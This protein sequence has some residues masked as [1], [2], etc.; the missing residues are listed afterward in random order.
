MSYK[1]ARSAH[2]RV[3]KVISLISLLVFVGIAPLSSVQAGVLSDFFA[4]LKK[5][6]ERSE[7]TST[8]NLQTIELPKPAMN[9]DPSAGRGGGDITIVDGSALMPEEGPAGTI[10]DIEK[11]K[12][13]TIS[14]YMVRPGDTLS[15][16]AKM[17]DVSVN[18]ILW[19]NDLPRASTLK[20]GQTLTILPVTGI[21]Y[22]IKKGDTLASIAKRYGGDAAE[23]VSYNGLGDTLVVGTMIIIPNGEV[24]VPVASTPSSRIEARGPSVSY[25]GY[26]IRPITGGVRSQGIHGY[27]GVDLAVTAGTLIVASASG[28]VIISREGG[29]NGGYGNYVVIRHA[30]GTQTLYAHNSRNAVGIG[31]PVVQGQVIAYVGATGRATGPHIHF[32]IRGGPRN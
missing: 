24:A 18:T 30:N 4:Y 21:K 31:E 3:G 14:I 19:A 20:V 12:N 29:W 7:S 28:D 9:V 1:T 17:F 15:G 10:A 11:P 32:E 16:I 23:I 22:T 25:D 2:L 26:Y 5:G 8:G 27:N 13:A 6:A